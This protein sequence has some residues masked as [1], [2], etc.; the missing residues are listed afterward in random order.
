MARTCVAVTGNRAVHT[1]S[2]NNR[3][4]MKIM[5][6]NVSYLYELES[7]L[8]LELECNGLFSIHTNTVKRI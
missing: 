2:H 3:K 8:S 4:E 6:A 5:F 7:S 1:S